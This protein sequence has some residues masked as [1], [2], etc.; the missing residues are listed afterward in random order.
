MLRVSIVAV[1]LMAC[2]SVQA[3]QPADALSTCFAD[4]TSGKDRKDL[5]RWI[6]LAMAAHPEMKEQA[7][8]TPPRQT[9]A[10]EQWP[11]WSV[12][13]LAMPA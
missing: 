8:P 2:V 3:Q 7:T 6:F 10:H 13:C 12:A 11:P 5:A 4:R 9:R 1:M